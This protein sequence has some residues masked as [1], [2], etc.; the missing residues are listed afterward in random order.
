MVVAM[1]G[2]ASDVMTIAGIDPNRMLRQYNQ[3]NKV[4]YSKIAPNRTDRDKTDNT[5]IGHVRTDHTR[6]DHG[7]MVPDRV[8]RVMLRP[9]TAIPMIATSVKVVVMI[10]GTTGEETTDAAAKAERG[11]VM[12]MVAG[13]IASA[14]PSRLIFRRS[15]KK[16]SPRFPIT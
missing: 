4:L 16:R 8:P 3:V 12:V 14:D 13:R 9:V 5:R 1:I 2:G 6:I 15:R 7:K 11:D 10:D